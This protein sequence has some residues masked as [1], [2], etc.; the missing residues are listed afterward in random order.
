MNFNVKRFTATFGL[1]CGALAGTQAWAA[2]VSVQ[3]TALASALGAP[4]DS[5][6]DQADA[7]LKQATEAIR[8]ADFERAEKLITA[9][10]NLNPRYSIFHFGVTPQKARGELRKA[11]KEKI[12]RPDAPLPSQRFSPESSLRESEASTTDPFISGRE[13]TDQ[14]NTIPA[15]DSPSDRLTLPTTNND[16]LRRSEILTD[17]QLPRDNTPLFA[18]PRTEGQNTLPQRRQPAFDSSGSPRQSSVHPEDS[19]TAV[20]EEPMRL[21]QPAAIGLPTRPNNPLATSIDATPAPADKARS[22]REQMAARLALAVGDVRTARKHLENAK[23]F[24]LSYQLNE[25]SPQKIEASIRKFEDVYNRREGRQQSEAWKRLYSEVLLDQAQGLLTYGQFEE[26]ER[27]VTDAQQLGVQY[28]SFETSPKT[29]MARIAEVK[30]AAVPTSSPRESSL[31]AQPATGQPLPS[32]AGA[33]ADKEEALS[34]TRAARQAMAAGDLNQAE[35]F[36]QAATKLGVPASLFAPG[37][38]RPDIVALDLQKSLSAQRVVQAGGVQESDVPRGSQAVYRADEDVT[39]NAQATAISPMI[40]SKITKSSFGDDL[41]EPA[42]LGPVDAQ[43]PTATPRPVAPTESAF[44]RGPAGE[45]LGMQFFE[46]GT[47]ALRAR[48]RTEALRLFQ[49]AY[50]YRDDMDPGSLQRLQDHLQ[51]LSVTKEPNPLEVRDSSSLLD[52]AAARQQ[53]LARQLSA[54]ITK[55]QADVRRMREKQPKLALERLQQLGQRVEESGLDPEPRGQLMT[56]VELSVKELEKYI[57]DNRAQIELDESNRAVLDQIDRRKRNRLEI[58]EKLAEMVDQFN[59]YRDQGEYEKMEVVAKRARELAPDDPIVRQMYLNA[60]HIVRLVGNQRLQD[61]KEEQVFRGLHNVDKMAGE[62]Y[63]DNDPFVHDIHR[64]NEISGPRKERYGRADFRKTPREMEIEQKLRHPVTLQFQEAPLGEVMDHLA[65]YAGINIHLDPRGMAEEGIT[66]TTPVSIVIS[67]EVMLKSA[68]NLILQPL[69]LS[70]VVKDEVLK[71]TSEQLR[72]GETFTRTYN[73]ADLVIPIPNFTPGSHLGLQGALNDAYAGMG[74]GQNPSVAVLASNDGGGGTGV[75]NPAMLGQMNSSFGPGQNS[76]MGPSSPGPGGLGG[77]AQADFDSL[78]ELITATIQPNTWDEVGGPGSVKEFATNLSLVVSQTQDVHEEIVDLLEQLRRLQDLQVTIEVR[79]I[80]LNDNFFERIGID[81][82]FNIEDNVSQATVDQDR[83]SPSASV[84]LTSSDPVMFTADLDIPFR[85]DSFALATPGFGTPVDVATFGFAI[86]SDIEAFFLVNAAQGD[87][88]S[89]ILQAP[90]V[91]LFNG[92]QAFV[93]D[94]SQTPFVI[95]VIPVVGDFAAAQQPVIVV[96][97]EGTFLTIQA[98]VSND[99]RYVRL[100]VVP[101]FSQIGDVE[102]FTFEGTSSTSNSSTTGGVDDNDNPL[103]ESNDGAVTR[104]GTTVQLPTFLF[105]TV[106]TTV[107]VPDGGTV[108]LGGIKRLSESRTEFGVPLLSKVPYVSRLFRNVGIGR[109]AE[110][111]MM[112][113]TPRII[114]QEEEEE[115]LGIA[116]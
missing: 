105:V 18:P 50:R 59:Q 57:K 54:D 109:D 85:Q 2:P 55:E 73:V 40:E 14:T 99:R 100:T 89:N 8:N 1:L 71:I 42:P 101:F 86:L 94:T 41:E 22:N 116:Q 66:S 107:S 43:T 79:F 112:M 6:R 51:M 9:A 103:P 80:R 58:Q 36:V 56:R 65:K 32:D 39:F 29:V 77:G 5:A 91:T 84:G 114:I 110:S 44:D 13:P 23:G 96:L 30:S 28:A 83:A 102:E 69:H 4:D 7:L 76:P 92:Q 70:Y 21:E 53:L 115:K 97:S 3:W 27:L 48:N 11:M 111:L 63:D 26:A 49:E 15:A 81:F 60:R 46:Q 108:L 17:S 75:L 31:L 47:Q 24:N 87:R 90:K 113:V 104:S 61:A 72:D 34:L 64:W 67:N 25:D 37:D 98:V 16:S 78:I 10:E 12:G 52:S 74:V 88:R 19:T 38:D 82:D 95:S 93:S 35:Q 62:H 20:P 68:L 33:A 106:T 45:G